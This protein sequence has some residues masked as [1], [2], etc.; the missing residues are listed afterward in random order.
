MTAGGDT[1]AQPHHGGSSDSV[2][3]TAYATLVGMPAS[4]VDRHILVFCDPRDLCRMAQVCSTLTGVRVEQNSLWRSIALQRWKALR[5]PPSLEAVPSAA[6]TQH[7]ASRD[8]TTH[9]TADFGAAGSWKARYRE[10]L[11]A[12]SSWHTGKVVGQRLDGHRASVCGAAYVGGDSQ[13]EPRSMLLTYSAD[14]S[15]KLWDRK[16]GMMLQWVWPSGLQ[17]SSVICGG[18]I[19]VDGSSRVLT[20]QR[21]GTINSW[22][23][24]V[25]RR[26][27]AQLPGTVTGPLEQAQLYE[28]GRRLLTLGDDGVAHE[29]RFEHSPHVVG[30]KRPAG[31][32][33]S[34]PFRTFQAPSSARP[35]VQ[36]PD[37]LRFRHLR[38]YHGVAGQRW[39]AMMPSDWCSL[40]AMASQDCM[41]H[42]VDS[43]RGQVR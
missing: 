23:A 21:T 41:V 16:N 36:E 18:L 3:F 1:N 30:G 11:G 40:V 20:V 19:N 31:S 17:G 27:A 26:W 43:E 6:S 13:L 29:W 10:L 8:S 35:E 37:S 15:I 42:F 7:S 2:F 28:N 22:D 5:P 12:E 24:P 39:T 25:S 38:T 4:I 34:N 14:G 33:G 9:G 32:V